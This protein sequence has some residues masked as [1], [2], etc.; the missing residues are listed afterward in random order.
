MN[1]LKEFRIAKYLT[2]QELADLCGVCLMTISNVENGKVKPRFSLIRKL[3]QT[4]KVEPEEL[5]F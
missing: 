3:S 2:Q 4:L 1:R 5:N